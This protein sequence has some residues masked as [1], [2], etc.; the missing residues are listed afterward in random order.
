MKQKNSNEW[1]I[2]III[3]NKDKVNESEKE[4]FSAN[5]R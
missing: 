4:V 3:F 5:Y 2:G 1:Y